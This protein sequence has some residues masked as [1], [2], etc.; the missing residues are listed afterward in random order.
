MVQVWK[1]SSL[2]EDMFDDWQKYSIKVAQH[3]YS[4]ILSG[5]WYLNMISYGQDWRNYY[6]VEPDNFT[7]KHVQCAVTRSNALY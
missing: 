4:M 1:D 7:R 2:N 5:P 3:G 6:S